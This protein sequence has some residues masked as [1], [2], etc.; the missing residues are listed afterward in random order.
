MRRLLPLLLLLFVPA[1][2]ALAN[3]CPLPCSGQIASPQSDRLLY[4]Q[5]QG[6]GG[7]LEAYDTRT[8]A[9]RFALPAGRS[10]ADGRW[11]VTTQIQRGQTLFLHHSVASGATVGGFSVPGRWALVGVSP[12]ARWHALTRRAAGSTTIAIAD[13][14]RTRIVHRVSL[15]GRFEVDTIS[16]DGRRLFLVEHL[17][18]R[19]YR[20]R[21]LDLRTG[22]LHVRPLKGA[23]EPSVMAG[24][25]WSGVASP[26]GKW[27][28]TL[29][30]NT[31]RNLAFVHALDL[32]RNRPTCIFLPGKGFEQL[33]RY[34]LT[35]SPDGR[36]L[37]AANPAVGS[38]AEID[39]RARKVIAVTRF[40]RSTF[41]PRTRG[42]TL[43][44]TI[45]RNG[46][47]LYFTDGRDLWAYDAA[48]RLVRGPY[49]TGGAIAGFGFGKGD[50]RV[51]ALRADGRLLTLDAA[52]GR[53][54]AL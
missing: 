54:L 23:G 6:E 1:P 36:R 34:A 13:A 29:Y 46:R 51:H 53:R 33:K 43:S 14:S 19:R 50:R 32:R 45:S 27:L 38:V 37:F 18:D 3:G 15:R 28:L 9:R 25:A 52:T 20:V 12:D 8:G 40:G 4:V 44:G 10:S 30:L 16:R 26:D 5:P 39:L 2:A 22:R 47:T 7:P 42:A 31:G 35:L 41:A 11:H 49:R 17:D 48:Y 24:L 21:L